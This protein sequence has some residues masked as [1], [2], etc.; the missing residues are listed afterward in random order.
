MAD[1]K[2][3]VLVAGYQDIAKATKDFDGL[4]SQVA[5]KQVE[6]KGV[7]LVTHDKDG[8]V[9]VRQT[10]DHLGRTGAGW[11]GGVGLAVGLFAPPLLASS[12]SGRSRA[13][14]SASS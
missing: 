4:L 1:T 11:G 13:E 6:I 7:I 2:T 5:D 9:A 3:D 12:P 10:G 14:W 8:N